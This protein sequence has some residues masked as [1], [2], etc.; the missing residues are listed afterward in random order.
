MSDK[1]SEEKDQGEEKTPDICGFWIGIIL[2]KLTGVHSNVPNLGHPV[3]RTGVLLI[4][5]EAMWEDKDT[6]NT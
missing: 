5:V 1:V 4:R 3:G 2:G 6:S